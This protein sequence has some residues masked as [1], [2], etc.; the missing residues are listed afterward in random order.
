[1]RVLV[2]AP[3]A[4]LG[5]HYETDLEIIQNHLDQGDDVVLVKCGGSLKELKFMGCKGLLRCSLCTSRC[6][7]G[8][9]ALENTAKLRQLSIED[10]QHIPLQSKINLGSLDEVKSYTYK[11]NDI[12]S[13]Y[14]SSLISD[15]RN[16]LPSMDKFLD[17]TRESLELLQSLVD[18]LDK[19]LEVE[20]PDLV[21]FFNGRFTLYR[22]L[23]RLCQQ[24]TIPFFVHERGA[25][26]SLYSLTN[27]NMPHDIPTKVDE[28]E[29][30][31]LRGSSEEN[32]RVAS[33][34][35]ENRARGEMGAWRS[36]TADQKENLLPKD[37]DQSKRNIS[38]YISSEDEFC[39]VPGWEMKIYKSQADAIKTICEHFINQQD[40]KFYVRM[41]PNLR[42]LDNFTTR[43]L[44]QLSSTLSNC[45]VIEP[46][47][48]VSTYYLLQKSEKIITFG[49]TVGVEATYWDKPSIQI[50]NSLYGPV[51]ASHIAKSRE[52]VIDLIANSELKTASKTAALKYGFWASQFGIKFKHYRPINLT[53]GKFK[54][55]IITG[56]KFLMGLSY[57]YTLLSDV[58]KVL[59][60]EYSYWHLQGKIKNKM[61]LFKKH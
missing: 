46:E 59:K 28:I 2:Y 20:K 42:G 12:G 33:T 23:L 18:H 11:D 25:N 48:L 55:K 50:G 22:P 61:T 60:G 6:E 47:S 9:E 19:I 37:W 49:S 4:V 34:W 8:V 24:K 40:L 14:I 5:H 45:T 7:L 29:E 53:T 10:L 21:Y 36:F 35:F 15:L 44:K 27:N 32:E 41:H 43:E 52:E 16:P 38:F 54:G 17:F 1:M 57:S 39:S 30:T 3:L 13:A 58:K 26:N 31:W 51:G 56:P